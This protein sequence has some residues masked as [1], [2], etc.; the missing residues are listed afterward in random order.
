MTRIMRLGGRLL[1]GAR[2]RGIG[3]GRTLGFCISGLSVHLVCLYFGCVC[4]SDVCISGFSVILVC[5]CIWFICISGCSVLLVRLHFW[6]FRGYMFAC[7]ASRN[8]HIGARPP[9]Q[10]AATATGLAKRMAWARR[11]GSVRRRGALRS[12]LVARDDQPV[13]GGRGGR[14]GGRDGRTD[15]WTDG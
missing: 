9:G 15:K 12:R 6:S 1:H 3:I 14:E 13:G 8:Q 5:L 2:G 7:M 4:I 11:P 10:G